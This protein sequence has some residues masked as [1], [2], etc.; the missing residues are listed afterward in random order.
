MNHSN[1]RLIKGLP[2]NGVSKYELAEIYYDS[3][4]RPIAYCEIKICGEDPEDV[5]DLLTDVYEA[6]EHEPLYAS[7]FYVEEP[8]FEL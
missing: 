6:F 5:H 8:L 3:F 1:Y 2:E 4:N 7:E